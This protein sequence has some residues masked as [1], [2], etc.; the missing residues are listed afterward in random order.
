VAAPLGY[1]AGRAYAVPGYGG[2]YGGTDTV[3]AVNV[4]NASLDTS[5][6]A[7]SD[8]AQGNDDD[9]DGDDDDSDDADSG[10]PNDD[11]DGRGAPP[12]DYEAPL[13][14][15][16]GAIHIKLPDPSA[17]ITFDGEPI[18]GRG[19]DRLILTPSIQAGKPFKYQVQATWNQDGQTVT[20]LR[21]GTVVAGKYAI[22]NFDAPANATP[23]ARTSQATSATQPG[24][25]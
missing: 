5:D 13:P 16:R 22:A 18:L 12:V 20:E 4:N 25:K 8:D 19:P 15:D 14:K 10:T 24:T 17:T 3:P 23:T 21:E 7:N 1:A 9:D 2:Y 11:V 6:N